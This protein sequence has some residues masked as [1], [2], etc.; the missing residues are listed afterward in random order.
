[1]DQRQRFQKALLLLDQNELERAEELL[2]ELVAQTEDLSSTV[3][4]RVV[5]G[6]LFCQL[7]RE[8]EARP[9][10]Q[11]ALELARAHE[12]LDVLE[13]EIRRAKEL[14]AELR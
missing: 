11:R 5:L 1:V 10:L 9:L 7:R 8:D 3:R 12:L 13:Y 6:D 14:L 4:A 2:R